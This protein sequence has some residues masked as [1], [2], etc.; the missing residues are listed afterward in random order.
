MSQT[1]AQPVPLGVQP[2]DKIDKYT[3]VEQIGAGGL[4][5]VWKALDPL[6][7]RHVAIKQI[8]LNPRDASEQDLP[9]RFRREA[10]LQ[11]NLATNQKLLVQVID[12][13][14][15]PR[16]MFLILEYVDGESLEQL[17]Q[18]HRGPMSEKQAL[19]I[20]GGI[21]MGLDVIHQQGA[22]HR[23]LKPSNILLPRAGGL[24]IGDFGLATLMA[25][26][27][28]L[29]QGSVRYMAPELFRDEPVDSRADLYALGMI[30]YE[31][32]AGREKFEDAFKLVLRDQRNQSLRWMKWHTNPRAKAPSLA[33]INP[34]V[35]A[36]LSDLVDRLMEKEQAKRV[37]SAREL[38]DAIRRHFAPGGATTPAASTAAAA[39]PAMVT[40]PENPTAPL[41]RRSRWP[42]ILTAL[43]VLQLLAVAGY[44]VV[45]SMQQKNQQQAA[46][47]AANKEFEQARADYRQGS[48]E[49]AAQ[50]FEKLAAEWPQDSHLGPGSVARAKLARA[51]LA[52]EQRDHDTARK[53]YDEVDRMGLLDRAE[54]D[55]LRREND[56]A[57]S[58]TGIL[59]E[60]EADIKAQRFGQAR[61]KMLDQNKRATLSAAERK[62]V[63]QLAHRLEESILQQEIQGVLDEARQLGETGRI[64]AAM[65]RLTDAQKKYQDPRLREMFN[66]LSQATQIDALQK[67]AVEA[68]RKGDL[69]TAIEAYTRLQT[70][71]PGDTQLPG[72]IK[73]L[74]VQVA[75]N[76]ARRLMQSGDTTAAEAAYNRVLALGEN[77]EAR[78]ALAN[79]KIAA[80]RQATLRAGDQAMAEGNFERAIT[81]FNQA[82]KLGAGPEVNARIN[83][84]K[85]RLQTIA[86]REAVRSND[87]VAAAEAYEAALQLLP[88][89]PEAKRG[90]SEVRR[91]QAYRKF[92]ASGEENR[93]AGKLT[94]AKSDFLKAR[95]QSATPDVKQRL[96]DMEYEI[97]IA[98][99][100][101]DMANLQW[102]SAR[103][104]LRTAQG[105]R[106]TEEVQSLLRQIARNLPD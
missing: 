3:V 20:L 54:I 9:A 49:K 8:L 79:I 7:N 32:L 104:W 21:A 97:L 78:S 101:R 5:V 50:A 74:R 27:E 55:R 23:D 56:T 29:S 72:K 100:K 30:A 46:L 41:P 48:F 43:I 18:K 22:V 89:D 106:N 13:I 58:F 90:L 81:Q 1:P 84:A 99:A 24:K 91:V 6:L 36:A 10:N 19:G 70:A 52:Q 85:A 71:Q 60:I 28:A 98:S 38:L 105:L 94:E 68:E 93:K 92:M 96:E 51:R 102:S 47:A 67:Q 103:A 73:E 69:A 42:L 35:P 87:L 63:E 39:T 12:L 17:L 83:V 76:E 77:A 45:S 62:S 25:D 66:K 57:I 31:M 75:L 26:Q 95:E 14:D 37:A 11:K 88:E 33:Q 82:L 15:E 61:Q 59:R 86:G 2:G 34:T 16:G 53:L 64:E 44:L 80:E 4:S 40:S 65:R